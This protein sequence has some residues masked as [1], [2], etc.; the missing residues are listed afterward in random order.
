MEMARD[1]SLA[2]I[3]QGLGNCLAFGKAGPPPPEAAMRFL[4]ERAGAGVAGEGA[5]S[6]L[7]KRDQ[8]Q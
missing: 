6:N 7:L 4:P 8:C 1:Y 2:V 5:E 3:L